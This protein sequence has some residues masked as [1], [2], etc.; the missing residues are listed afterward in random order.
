LDKSPV[1]MAKELKDYCS[2]FLY[3]C[4][5]KEGLMKGTDLGTIRKLRQVTKNKISI[6]GGISTFEEVKELDRINVDCVVGMAIYKGKI[7]PEEF[8]IESLNFKKMNNLIPTIIKD[9]AGNVLMLAYSNK[10]SLQKTFETGRCWYFSRERKRLWMKGEASGNIQ[11]II[12]IKT[13]CDKDALLFIVRQKRNACHLN[14]YSCFEEIKKFNLEELYKIIKNRIKTEDQNSYSY[15]LYINPRVLNNKIIEEA[16][17]L[18][19]TKN[20]RQ[21]RWESADLIYFLIVF[22]VKRGIKINDIIDKLEERNKMAK[23]K[24]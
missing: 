21:V 15:S 13:D 24:N 22:L 5:E 1:E 18:T 3:T 14:N 8:F 7:N 2:E 4:I 10:E 16:I 23:N 17:E 20:R 19:K 9:I 6:A 12:E 11:E